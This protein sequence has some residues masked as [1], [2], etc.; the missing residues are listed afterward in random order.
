MSIFKKG[1]RWVVQVYEANTGRMR[2]VGTY[3]TRREAKAAEADAAKITGR[4]TVGTF[5]ARWTEDFP[6]PKASTNKHNEER[7]RRFAK[8]YGKR[9][10]HT[11]TRSETQVWANRHPSEIHSLRAMFSDALDVGLIKDNPF[12]RLRVPRSQGRQNLEG[13]WLDEA[14]IG[15][16]EDCARRVHGPYGEMFAALIRFAAYT[17]MRPGELFALR[18]EDLDGRFINIRRA[19]DSKTR[20][21]GLPKNGE[22][23]RIVYPQIAREAVDSMPLFHGQ[24]LVFVA[25]RGGQLWSPR[26]SELWRP[27][28]NLFGR[29]EMSFYETRHFC[30]T[31]LLNK[32]VPPWDVALQLGHRDN[33]KLVLSTYGHPSVKQGQR[34]LL[35]AF[36]G[37]V[38]ELDEVRKRKEAG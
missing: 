13:D 2:Q 28:R 11:I 26:L 3:D 20:T 4:E 12:S 38:V 19:A 29:P 8:E 22:P 32:G 7:T 31:Y 14:D 16:L 37:D 24:T 17:G 15:R 36:D 18:F 35:Q 1:N 25:P 5:Q 33:G 9:G 21:V 27:V 6:R 34:R 10:M 23:R 30:A